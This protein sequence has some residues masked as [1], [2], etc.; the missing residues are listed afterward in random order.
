MGRHRIYWDRPGPWVSETRREVIAG[1]KQKR[2]P[3]TQ[4]PEAEVVP[5]L[6][7]KD[8]LKLTLL[9]AALR[10]S[11]NTAKGVRDSVAR[12]RAQKAR[13]AGS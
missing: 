12:R 9:V 4:D 10:R 7:R 5:G 2:A 8:T 11:E 1:L 3:A 6:K 13:Q